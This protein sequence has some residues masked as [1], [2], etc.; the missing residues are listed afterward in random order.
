MSACAGGVKGQALSITFTS[1]T[2]TLTID[3]AKA[4]LDK[5]G[6]RLH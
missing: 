2:K 4:L 3:Q 5:A 1:P 6:G